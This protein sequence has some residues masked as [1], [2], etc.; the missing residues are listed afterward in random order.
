MVWIF[1]AAVGLESMPDADR[2]L[3]IPSGII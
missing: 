2:L 1:A 3:T